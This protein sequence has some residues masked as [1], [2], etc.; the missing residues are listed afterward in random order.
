MQKDLKSMTINEVAALTAARGYKKFQA[1]YIF[2]FVHKKQVCDIADI[3]PLPKPMRQDLIEQSYYI[4]SLRVEKKLRDRDGT[5]KYLFALEDGLAI[6]S[7][8]IS[9][10]GRRTL[11][12]STQVG[13]A[14]GC[15][16]CATAKLKIQRNLTAGE[17][18]DQLYKVEQNGPAVTNVVYMGMGEAMLNYDA[19]MSSVR[20]LNDSKGRNLGAR[21]IT[22]STCGIIPCIKRLGDEDIQPRLAVSLNAPTGQLRG[23]IMP[24]NKK[25]PLRELMQAVKSYQSKTGNRVT[26]EYVMI[27]D[28][29]ETSAHAEMLGKLI[30]G[31]KCNVNLIEYNPHPGCQMRPAERKS[32]ERF[33]KLL[34]DKGIETTVRLKK[35]SGIKAACGQL[36]AEMLINKT[37]PAEQQ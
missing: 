36:G 27:K 35:G 31:I 10:Q 4:S 34:T 14:M 19:V 15:A 20:I 5:V 3:T 6:E 37:L 17:I 25:Y 2:D 26:F 16:F 9:E 29:N 13:C 33:S 30:K 18:V 7:V 11:C 23:K 22:I 1:G 28:F 21:R 8:L 12:I 24:V 32:I